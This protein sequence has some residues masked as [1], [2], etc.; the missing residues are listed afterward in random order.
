MAMYHI[1]AN[2]NCSSEKQFSRPNY[3]TEPQLDYRSKS[4]CQSEL[5]SEFTVRLQDPMGNFVDSKINLNYLSSL[6]IST[7]S[8]SRNLFRM[9]SENCLPPSGTTH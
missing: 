5:I 9:H 4:N 1:L 2:K 6:E 3:T 7:I 8:A